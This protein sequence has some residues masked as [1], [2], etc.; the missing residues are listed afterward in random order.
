MVKTL[1]PDVSVKEKFFDFGA[2]TT[3]EE[4]GDR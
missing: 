2:I 1:V 3:L 4:S